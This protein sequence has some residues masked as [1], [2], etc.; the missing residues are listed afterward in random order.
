[1]PRAPNAEG[2]RPRRPSYAP[3]VQLKCEAAARTSSRAS[4]RAVHCS[5]LCGTACRRRRS[6]ARCSS[7]G[8]CRPASAVLWEC[9]DIVG[10]CGV[11]AGC[12]AC[13]G[14]RFPRPTTQT[15]LYRDMY[16][17]GNESTESWDLISMEAGCN[18]LTAP[19][20][21]ETQR[22]PN[23]PSPSAAASLVGTST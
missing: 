8:A 18:S 5:E 14:K 16:W 19:S 7:T 4:P 13:C 17:V 23:A 15:L 3:S 2:R 12:W 22:K 21:T 9:A 11:G 20:A 6:R 10:P 1:M